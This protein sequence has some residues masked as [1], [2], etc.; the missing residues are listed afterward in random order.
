ME[1]GCPGALT[2][3]LGNLRRDLGASLAPTGALPFVVGRAGQEGRSVVREVCLVTKG[4]GGHCYG[5]LHQYG[6]SREDF[7]GDPLFRAACLPKL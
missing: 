3:K 6:G 4:G 7:T 5:P 1:E 2:R